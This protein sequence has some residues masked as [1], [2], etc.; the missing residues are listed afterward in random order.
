MLD[1]SEFDTS[2]IDNLALQ[3]GAL[4][5]TMIAVGII[6]GYILRVCKVPS[7]ISGSLSSVAALVAGFYWF[8]VFM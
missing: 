7:R 2:V 6:I 8:Q 3:F 1:L 5:F 4:A